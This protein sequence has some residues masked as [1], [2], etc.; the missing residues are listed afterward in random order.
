MIGVCVTGVGEVPEDAVEDNCAFNISQPVSN[1][2]SKRGRE[3]RDWSLCQLDWRSAGSRC[4]E[5]C[6]L[7]LRHQP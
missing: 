6:A 7:S 1:S 5:Q 3:Q 2:A 4:R